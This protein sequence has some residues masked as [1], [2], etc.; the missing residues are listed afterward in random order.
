M[1]AEDGEHLVPSR[2]VCDSSRVR[3]SRYARKQLDDKVGAHQ[4]R[5]PKLLVGA[6]VGRQTFCMVATKP[7][8]ACDHKPAARSIFVT[9]TAY[10][11]FRPGCSCVQRALDVVA[12]IAEHLSDAGNELSQRLTALQ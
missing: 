11:P 10:V 3:L 6:S 2:S 7:Q 9:A 12:L 1:V 5:E 4:N 8:R